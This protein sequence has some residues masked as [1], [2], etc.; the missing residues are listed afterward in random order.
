M[1]G[2]GSRLAVAC[3]AALGVVGAL[4][5]TASGLARVGRATTASAA[6]STTVVANVPPATFTSHTAGA[7][8]SPI[9]V[10]EATP[11]AI[12]A[13]DVCIWI[14][15]HNFFDTA[16]TATASAST[17]TGAVSP[18]VSYERPT[19]RS[20]A[21]LPAAAYAVFSV[22]TASS[23]AP[24]VY[25]VS[26]IKVDAGG[27]R[28]AVQ[29]LVSWVPATASRGCETAAKKTIGAATAFSISNG[30]PTQISGSTAAATAA[31]V[32]ET[33][34]ST[35]TSGTRSTTCIGFGP[36]RSIGTNKTGAGATRPVILAT[37]KTFQDALASQYLAG[38]LNT[39]TLLTNPATLPQAT[40][41]A[42]DKEGVT[43]VY[44]VGGPLAVSTAVVSAIEKM[45][46]RTC[47]G[48]ATLG[49][50]TAPLDIHVTRIAGATQYDTAE[51][52]AETVAASNVRSLA[53][54]DAYAGV[55]AA[56]GSGAYNET[57][58]SATAAPT[59]T[60]P[61]ATAF[62]ANGS[63]FQDA[64]ASSVASYATRIPTLLTTPS[65]LSSQAV[66]AI[67]TLGIKQVVVLGG[68]L[69]VANTVVTQL[70]KIGVAALRIAGKT[71]VDTAI[72]LARFEESSSAATGLH[73]RTGTTVA[74]ARG[75][76]FSDGLAGAA[77]AGFGQYPQLL[78]E[79]STLAGTTL[80]QFLQGSG[81]SGTGFPNGRKITRLVIFGGSLA[82]APA[83]ATQLQT[84]IG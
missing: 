63:E 51:R 40:I 60:V 31:T 14:A 33:A 82:I 64:E 42:L 34:F 9:S 57:A 2:S 26:G 22:T 7:P 20:A 23:K 53:F 66:A 36:T 27:A 62:L 74:I 4:S 17:G 25:R 59:S 65:T 50:A 84:A 79:S 13:G 67:G 68:P 32:L 45:P 54:A 16:G 6:A 80:V 83:L 77:I 5:G 43:L 76:G 61:A 55:N 47:G 56:G 19:G 69:A 38:V 8:I 3:V 37:D 41:D 21:T 28:G 49:T 12:L 30:A 70:S 24:S 72:E 48:S 29:V 18:T 78:T 73:W 10:T 46:A 15:G 35:A 75:N 1:R 44:V 11:G 71:D 39:G 81:M 58:G 52:I